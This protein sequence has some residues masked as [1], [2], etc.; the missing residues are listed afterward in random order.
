MKV[1][2]SDALI[3][4]IVASKEAKYIFTVSENGIGKISALEEYREQ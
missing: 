2:S 4:G 3:E 1:A